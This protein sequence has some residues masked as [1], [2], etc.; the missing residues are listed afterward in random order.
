MQG[1]LAAYQG[2]HKVFAKFCLKTLM[3]GGQCMDVN[4]DF[5]LAN[6]I[7]NFKVALPLRVDL[8]I[9]LYIVND[10]FFFFFSFF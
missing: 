2:L 9:Y 1:V 3:P 4:I 5:R 8:F 6:N 7:V 10:S